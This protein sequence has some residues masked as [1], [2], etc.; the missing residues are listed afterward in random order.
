MYKAEDIAK[1]VIYFWNKNKIFI[2]HLKLQNLLFVLQMDYCRITGERLI[3]EDFY[4]W[5]L[6]ARIISLYEKYQCNCSYLY[7][8]NPKILSRIDLI[9][10]KYILLKYLYIETWDLVNYVNQLDPVKYTFE[11]FG[12]GTIIPYG[13]ILNL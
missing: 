7:E 12:S 11:I 13:S 2:T 1:Y 8:N 4:T 6:G 5:N 3:E 10:V 9:I